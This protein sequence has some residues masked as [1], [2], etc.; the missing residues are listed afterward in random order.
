MLNEINKLQ[1]AQSPEAVRRT[2]VQR[3]SRGDKP[4]SRVAAASQPAAAA[5]SSSGAIGPAPKARS[6]WLARPVS[7]GGRVNVAP[8]QEVV[9]EE[10]QEEKQ[11][12]KLR[13]ERRWGKW[14]KRVVQEEEQESVSRKTKK[15]RR[16]EKRRKEERLAREEEEGSPIAATSQ[17]AD[18]STTGLDA[19]LDPGDWERPQTPEE[20]QSQ[21]ETSESAT[22]EQ[23]RAMQGVLDV[24]E[25]WMHKSKRKGSEGGPDSEGKRPKRDARLARLQRARQLLLNVQ[26]GGASPEELGPGRGDQP[27]SSTAAPSQNAHS[28][29]RARDF[30]QQM[31]YTSFDE[32]VDDQTLVVQCCYESAHRRECADFGSLN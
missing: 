17:L 24:V 31:G 28:V 32:I 30:M 14:T 4:A 5:S 27:A 6:K 26:A 3:T 19:D 13:R 15:K 29:R 2:S 11:T 7:R 12:K 9:K 22:P 21:E 8:S 18:T 25:G 20:D 10:E 23:V 1:P 16:K